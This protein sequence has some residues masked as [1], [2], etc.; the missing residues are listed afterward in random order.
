MSKGAEAACL[1]LL[2]LWLTTGGL[3]CRASHSSNGEQIP[4]APHAARPPLAFDP[5]IVELDGRFGVSSSRDFPLTGELAR[6]ATPAIEAIEGDDVAATVIPSGLSSMQV[7]GI[8]LTI[9]GHH[10][11]DRVGHV[12]VSTGLPDPKELVLYFRSRVPGTLAVS[13]SNPYLDLRLTP[14]HVVRLS[15]SSSRPDFR[16]LRAEV[17]SGPFAARIAP[18]APDGRYT[19]EIEAVD[20]AVATGQRGFAGRLLLVSNDPAEPQKEV[21]LLAM[22]DPTRR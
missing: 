12:V 10:V 3:G 9:S 15:V 14:P 13:P 22:G 2:T 8:R 1:A 5:S 6:E 21:A 7:P 19:V 20:S 17:T 18:G 11:G 16:L 4:V